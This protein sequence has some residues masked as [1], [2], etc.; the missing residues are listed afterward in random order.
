[1][2]LMTVPLYVFLRDKLW[3]MRERLP[4]PKAFFSLIGILEVVPS[5]RSKRTTQSI[6][7]LAMRIGEDASQI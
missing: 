1:M 6:V 3:H 5:L 4:P 2:L 7:W